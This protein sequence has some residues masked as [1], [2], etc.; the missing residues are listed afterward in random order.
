[1][2]ILGIETSTRIGG[3]ALIDDKDLIAECRLNIG[4]VHSE[5]LMIVIDRL[6]GD[7]G[8]WLED[9]DCIAVSIGPGS[10]TGLRI[11]LSTAKGISTATGKPI[12]PVPT[13]DAMAHNMRVS[14]CQICPMID[15]RKK[16]VYTAIFEYGN[17]FGMRRITD[18]MVDKPGKILD[19]ICGEAI[20]VGDGAEA[21]HDLIVERL[22][23]K[24]LFVPNGL[25]SSAVTVAEVGSN[26]FKNGI[27]H[28]KTLIPLYIRKSEA[29]IKSQDCKA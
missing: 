29:E 6:L 22:G 27:K 23:E 7:A 14:R 16:E 26:M 18:Y 17:T 24:A 8:I 13:L 2:L 25:S 12:I 9:L 10:F 20:F 1:M 28:E 5:K 4:M 15:A 11:G 21:Y 3:I 19:Y